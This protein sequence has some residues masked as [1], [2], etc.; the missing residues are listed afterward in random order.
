MA[1]KTKQIGKSLGADAAKDLAYADSPSAQAFAAKAKDL[2]ALREAVVDAAGVGA[3][4]WLSYLFLFFYLFIAVAAV[5]HRDFLFENP[6]K[7]PFLD[8]ELPLLGFFVL[9]PLLFLVLHA[10]V[11]LH[12]AMLAG[13]VGV[14][15][16]ELRAQ[17][18]D[19][20]TRTRLRRQLP[21]NIFVQYLAGPHEVRTGVMGF[22]LRLIALITLVIFPI[23][24]FVFFQLQFLPYH[25]A[26]ITWWLRIAVLLDI[27]LLWT[28]WPS[29][30]RGQA[31]WISWHDFRRP[32]IIALLSASL[33]PLLLVFTIAT[34]PGEWLDS[35]LPSLP[36]VP[37][38]LP[39]LDS[40]THCGRGGCP[41]RWR[42]VVGFVKSMEWTSLHDLL[43]AGDVDL[44]ARKPKSLW[45]NRLVL[46]G[47]DVIDH[48]TFDSEEKIEALRE[49]LSLRDRRLERAVLI[50]SRLRKA[51]L[52]AARLQGADLERADLREA[53]LSCAS[54]KMEE[55]PQEQDCAQLQGAILRSA[56]LQGAH[57]Q[58]AELQ[59]ADLAGA[60]L[61]GADLAGAKLQ[62]ADLKKAELQGAD[63]A[64]AKL[65]GADL[66]GAK[67]QGADL[68]WAGLQGANLGE[69]PSRKEPLGGA[70]LQGANLAF[71]NVWLASFPAELER[72]PLDLERQPL[73]PLGVANLEMSPLTAEAKASLTEELQ[74]E[75]TDG[76][77]LKTLLDRLNPILRT[78]P[79][80]WEDED[81]W[82]RYIKQTKQPSFD[83]T[84]A[85]LARMACEDPEGHIAIAMAERAIDRSGYAQPLAKALLNETCKGA[86]ALTDEK[87]AMLEKKLGSAPE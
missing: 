48:A 80:K 28:L 13:K 21:S 2:D 72:Q 23:A 56:Q 19:E 45:S 27:L 79:E 71:A 40:S 15:H 44:I 1:S 25:N 67:L 18:R 11:L 10:Y 49:T 39:S 43:V 17:I 75:I 36:L 78:D 85:F 46:P 47:I 33:V 37:T 69:F 29:T 26:P 57:L 31:T 9:G 63:L 65:Q 77:L 70:E 60:K 66:A 12:F 7:L 84:V 3:G 24:L 50:D 20:D 41:K 16:S 32:R 74:A 52:T 73:V 76:E 64:G 59:G 42:R 4:L 82:S 22:M 83:E 5:T 81:S 53:E 61:Q 38:H 58:S 35:N 87:R 68:K 86:K 54:R 34:F 55:D 6:V 62:G 30:A 8:V 14:F 51:D